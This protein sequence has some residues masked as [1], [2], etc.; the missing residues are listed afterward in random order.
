MGAFQTFLV[1]VTIVIVSI[2]TGIVIGFKIGVDGYGNISAM[3][4]EC[5][6][7]L[8]RNEYCAIIA[9]PEQDLED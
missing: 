4:Q 7:D 9:V 6:K 2:F 5:Q 1:V 3:V 8:P